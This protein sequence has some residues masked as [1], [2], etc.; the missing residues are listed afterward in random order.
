MTAFSD[1]EAEIRLAGKILCV[2]PKP[3]ALGEEI[4]LMVKLRVTEDGTIIKEDETETHFRRTKLIA[5]WPAGTPG[6][7]T[8]PA[9]VGSDGKVESGDAWDSAPPEGTFDD[10]SDAA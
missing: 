7:P 6:P 4:T 9:L 5:A 2:L 3:P 8:D 10:G 1:T